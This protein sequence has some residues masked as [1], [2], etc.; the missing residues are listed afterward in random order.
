M[1]QN[2]RRATVSTTRDGR[3]WRPGILRDTRKP[4]YMSTPAACP[5]LHYKLTP[6]TKGGQRSKKHPPLNLRKSNTSTED[7]TSETPVRVCRY[8]EATAGT[9]L[10]HIVQEGSTTTKGGCDQKREV[11]APPPARDYLSDRPRLPRTR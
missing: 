6:T 3:R 9:N 1:R 7:T 11:Q 4:E 2:R 10:R 5:T 8:L